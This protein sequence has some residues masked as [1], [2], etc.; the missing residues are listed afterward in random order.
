[1][2]RNSLI[3]AF[4]HIIFASGHINVIVA[5][6]EILYRISMKSVTPVREQART[7]Q[8]GEEGIRRLLPVAG[9]P[10]RVRPSLMK[11]SS[12]C[13]TL[14][15]L[16][17]ACEAHSKLNQASSG[18]S[19]VASAN[20]LFRVAYAFFCALCNCGLWVASAQEYEVEGVVSFDHF[21]AKRREPEV[22]FHVAVRGPKWFIRTTRP[23]KLLADYEEAAYDGTNLYYV[24]SIK[25]A[26]G[27]RAATGKKTGVNNAIAWIYKGP[28][29]HSDVSHIIAPVWFAYASSRYLAALTN[30]ELEPVIMAPLST[31][32]YD[33]A[34]PF[35]QHAEITLS[36][37]L[38]NLPMRVV[39]FEDGF[40]RD[41]MLRAP[42]KRKPPYDKGFT[43]AVYSAVNFTNVGGYSLPTTATLRIYAPKDDQFAPNGLGTTHHDVMLHSQY[44]I[45]LTRATPQTSL[46]EFQPKLLPT[47]VVT[48][49]RFVQQQGLL[50]PYLSDS[51][52]A[53]VAEI[54]NSKD[55][56]LLAAAAPPFRTGL[57][58]KP[59]SHRVVIRILVVFTICASS[60]LFYNFARRSKD[61]G[62]LATE[63]TTR[64]DKHDGTT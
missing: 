52:W 20:K 60:I 39:F 12:I 44:Q 43:N 32:V 45:A 48:D 8:N 18:I 17:P 24:C 27:Q 11:P 23:D 59:T 38:P 31:G 30:S 14:A 56:K 6:L 19:T 36:A 34:V 64:K 57:F 4:G 33:L 54:T 5:T 7:V 16:S 50:V 10:V 3:C 51:N 25:T 62:R 53:T 29:L 28:V 58:T 13:S 15:A 26:V 2:G 9:A 40:L 37:S 35:K 63:T 49:A 61:V 42:R 47:S 21:V 22:S 55:F 1:M 46:E 41:E